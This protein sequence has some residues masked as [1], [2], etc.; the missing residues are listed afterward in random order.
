MFRVCMRASLHALPAMDD[1]VG[2][3]RRPGGRGVQG[4]GAG[5]G[6]QQMGNAGEG[7]AVWVLAGMPIDG[8]GGLRS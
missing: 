8:A 6:R 2:H 7:L 5:V 1:S 3:A 4:S